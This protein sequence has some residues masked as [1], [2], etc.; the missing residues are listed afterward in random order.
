MIRCRPSNIDNIETDNSKPVERRGRKAMDLNLA[1]AQRD[2][3]ARLPKLNP[4]DR[5]YFGVPGRFLRPGTFLFS[6]DEAY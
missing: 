3:I 1:N 2:K 6:S 5:A 4:H